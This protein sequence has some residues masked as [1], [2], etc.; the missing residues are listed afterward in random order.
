VPNFKIHWQ[1]NRHWPSDLSGTC[2]QLP[3]WSFSLRSGRTTALQ[4][5]SGWVWQ[6]VMPDKKTFRQGQASNRKRAEEALQEALSS[7]VHPDCT[8]NGC[9]MFA[10]GTSER[11][12]CVA[13]CRLLR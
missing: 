2:A 12:Q 13:R 9:Y 5:G 4:E 11:D 3:G 8:Q 1:S 10:E 7:A 6:Y